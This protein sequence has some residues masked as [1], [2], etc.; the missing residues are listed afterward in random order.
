MLKRILKLAGI[1]FLIGTVIGNLIAFLT[2]NSDTGGVT[3]ASQKLLEIA[4][5]NGALALLLQSVFSGL[6][7]A[8]CF[9]GITLYDAERLPLAAATALHCSIIVFT[10]IPVSLLLGWISE[11]TEI[12]LM[13]A[14]QIV[15]FFIIW[16]ILYNVYKKQVRELNEMQK[17]YSDREK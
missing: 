17:D 16:L 9:G 12:L 13:A 6:Y 5:G 7:G 14:I 11:I 1:G 4:G 10:F 8:L 2:G 15:C 3:Y